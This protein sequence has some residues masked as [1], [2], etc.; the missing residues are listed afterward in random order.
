MAEETKAAEVVT[1]PAGRVINQSMFRKDQYNERAVPK[2][3]VEIAFPKGSEADIIIENLL[4]DAAIERWGKGADENEDLKL[5]ILDGDKLAK[6]R[7][8]KGKDGEAYKGMIV[9]R[10]DTIY[11]ADG[12][13]AAGGIAV[14]DEEVERI[15]AANSGAIYSG[16]FGCAAVVVGAYEGENDDGDKY[17]ALKF[18]LSAFQKTGDG[19]KLVSSADKSGLFKAVG[20]EKGSEGEGRR[21]RR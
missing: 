7:E 3:K 2:Y 12:E 5:P 15:E 10:A 14:Y 17:P 13:D 19:E 18:Y 9:I 1:L 4:L 11:N 16:C 8:K 20:R 21:R 6:K